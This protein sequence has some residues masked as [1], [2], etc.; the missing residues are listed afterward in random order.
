MKNKI[1]TGI[2]VICVLILVIFGNFPGTILGGAQIS[3]GRYLCFRYH[4]PFDPGQRLSH[5]APGIQGTYPL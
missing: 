4:C 2:G 3:K 5:S 1:A